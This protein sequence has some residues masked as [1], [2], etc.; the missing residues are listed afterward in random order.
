[1]QCCACAHSTSVCS[2]VG[3]AQISTIKK[4]FNWMN[5]L[6]VVMFNLFDTDFICRWDFCLQRIFARFVRGVVVAFMLFG[7]F[8]VSIVCRFFLMRFIVFGD[9]HAKNQLCSCSRSHVKW[10]AHKIHRPEQTHD[11]NSHN[12]KWNFC[13]VGQKHSTKN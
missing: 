1:M 13:A 7:T 3:C 4:T 6:F 2:A 8:G 9:D 10:C 5:K 11:D 12:L